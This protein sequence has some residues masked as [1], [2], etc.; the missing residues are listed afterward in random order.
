MRQARLGELVKWLAAA[1]A[2]QRRHADGTV[3]NLL[4]YRISWGSGPLRTQT[5]LSARTA[6]RRHPAAFECAAP[7]GSQP[8]QSP[9][10]KQ[11]PCDWTV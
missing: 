6:R 11:W 2:T 7:L 8:T 9:S 10:T 3:W 1:C 4:D 5:T